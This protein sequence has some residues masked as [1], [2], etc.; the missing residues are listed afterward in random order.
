VVVPFGPQ[1]SPVLPPNERK[2]VRVATAVAEQERSMGAIH[3][4]GVI[5][6]L[7]LMVHAT[8]CAIQRAPPCRACL[9]SVAAHL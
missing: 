9:L 3:K 1:I 2:V 5:A 6:S 7:L 4:M 8:L